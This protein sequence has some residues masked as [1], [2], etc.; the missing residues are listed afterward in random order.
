MAYRYIKGVQKVSKCVLMRF[1]GNAKPNPGNISCGVVFYSNDTNKLLYEYGYY[2]KSSKNNNESECTAL[3][4]GLDYALQND[5]YDITIEGD[6]QFV[7]STFIS[8]ENPKGPYREYYEKMNVY[9]EIFDTI[10]IRHIPR[11]ENTYA[12]MLA[13]KAYDLKQ[14]FETTFV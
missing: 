10:A 3:I 2:E 11:S 13:R 9:K 6:S 5:I 4:K 12:D 7:I 1:D 14:S 8:K